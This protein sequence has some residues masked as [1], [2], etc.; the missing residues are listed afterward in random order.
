M[1]TKKNIQRNKKPFVH[2]DT[3]KVIDGEKCYKAETSDGAGTHTIYLSKAKVD[4][5]KI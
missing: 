4:A 5:G 3:I 2:Y 1:K